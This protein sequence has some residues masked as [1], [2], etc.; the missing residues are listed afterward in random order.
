VIP[1][2]FAVAAV[3]AQPDGAW[4]FRDEAVLAGRGMITYRAVEL[5]D[6]P[7]VP[8]PA[9]DLTVAGARYGLLP[10]GKEPAEYPAV[11]WHSNAAGGPRVWVAGGWHAVGPQPV[12][13]PLTL[14]VGSG[15]AVRRVQRTVLIR[16]SGDGLSYAVRGYAAGRLRL[17]ATTTPPS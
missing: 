6:R 16:R 12:A 17:A 5:R 13:V 9:A 8:L 2:L 1:L 11:V 3:A 14:A 7:V 4:E 15:D 10:V